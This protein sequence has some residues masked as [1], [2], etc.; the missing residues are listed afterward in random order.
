MNP[1]VFFALARLKVHSFNCT[2]I[3]RKIY[4]FLTMKDLNFVENRDKMGLLKN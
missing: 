1:D 3:F 2:E 4:R